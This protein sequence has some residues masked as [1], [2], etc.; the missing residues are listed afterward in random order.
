[1]RWWLQLLVYF[2]RVLINYWYFFY[3]PILLFHHDTKSRAMCRN[4]EK[5]LRS[6]INDLGKI[7]F[8]LKVTTLTHCDDGLWKLSVAEIGFS[9]P[10]VPVWHTI[11][12][13][14]SW[15]GRYATFIPKFTMNFMKPLHRPLFHYSNLAA[16]R[17]SIL[18]AILFS[19]IRVNIHH[20]TGQYWSCDAS[21]FEVSVSR[22]IWG[23]TLK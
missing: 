15:W 4:K 6:K 5:S 23:S 2:C 11:L 21:I 17:N 13:N 12:N 8:L 3:R 18:D 10:S 14:Y 9:H 20:A 19:S 1:M 7:I 22:M 16:N